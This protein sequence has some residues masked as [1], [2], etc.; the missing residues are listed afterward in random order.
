MVFFKNVLPAI[1]LAVNLTESQKKW[2]IEY[3]QKL[4]SAGLTETKNKV[5]HF[6]VCFGMNRLLR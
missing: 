1:F 4:C 5:N 3:F 6:Q 2:F